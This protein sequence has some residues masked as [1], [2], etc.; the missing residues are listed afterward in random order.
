MPDSEKTSILIVDDLPE[1]HLV[2]RTVLEELGQEIV[3]VGSGPEALKQVLRKDFAVILL[4]VQM[5]EMDGFETARLIRQRRSSAH[6]PII[7]LTAFA[8]EVKLAQGYATGGVDYISTPVVPEVLRAKIKVFVEL[9]R[10]RQQVAR[11]AE[12]QARRAA[13]EESAR[14]F[15]FLAEASRAL[16]SSLDFEATLRTLARLPVPRLADVCLVTLADDRGSAGRTECAWGDPERGAVTPTTGQPLIP[17]DW[18]AAVVIRVLANDNFEILEGL[19]PPIPLVR[20]DQG[21]IPELLAG[22]VMALPLSARGRTL[23]VLTLA[24]APSGRRFQAGDVSLAHELAGRAAIALDNALLVRDIQEN[25]RRKNEFLAMLAHELRNP[26][27]PVRSAVHVL[28]LRG[29]SM[30]EL[31]WA[32]EVI[33]RQVTHLVRLVDDLLDVSRITR[34]KIRLQPEPTEAAAVV[35]SAVETSR[36]VIEGHQH[37]LTVTLPEG[38]VRL[39]ADPA[40]LA[41]VLA[42]L[43]NNAAKY[44]PEGGRIW[45]TVERQEAEAVFR[46]RDSGMGIPREMLGKVFDLFTQIDSSLDRAQGGLGI[47]L[48]MVRRLVELHGGSV[49]AL[50]DGPGKGAEFVI[51]LPALVEDRGAAA[52]EERPAPDV[53][54]RACRVLVV[55]DNIDA[56]ESLAR[57]LRLHGHE[58]RLAFNGAS[59]LEVARVFRCEAVVLDIGL[60]GMDGYEVARRLRADPETRDVLLI[61][62]SGYGQ[63]EDRAMSHE[64]GFNHHLVK[65]VDYAALERLLPAS[66]RPRLSVVG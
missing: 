37:Q 63:E 56:A 24:L 39:N 27:A 9:F 21:E 50:S 16:A 44:T 18:L 42:N 2:Y 35:A 52:S 46:V 30:P 32:R 65:P 13:A 5:P 7:F 33:D 38:P 49:Q 54:C 51:R 60:P 62:A 61:A 3:S 12:E 11:Q 57:L 40:R 47:G 23:G 31:D 1:K 66:P 17:S 41:Q 45:L 25:D 14:R 10:M 43:L 22:S 29:P 55:D 58:V 34:G 6:T 59:A 8:D 26:L 36:P 20:P 19:N 15:A 53:P 64:A 48:T 28:H 4:D